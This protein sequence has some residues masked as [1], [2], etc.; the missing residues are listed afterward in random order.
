MPE[1]KILRI[2]LDETMLYQARQGTFGFASRVEKAFT[3][4]GFQV[5]FREN[6]FDERVK[7][8]ARNGYSMF[9][10]DDPFHEKA[11]T[12]RKAYY[13]PFWRIEATPKRWEFEVAQKTF[14]PDEIDTD[15]A[16]FWAGNWRKWLFK[17]GPANATQDGV[18]YV[19][20]QGRLLERRS[21]QSMSPMDMIEEVRRKA[22]ERHILLGLHPGETYSRDELD[23]VDRMSAKDGRIAVQTGGMEVALR[24]CDLVVTQNS[25][26]ALSGFFFRKPAVLFAQTDFHHQMPSALD[27][28]VDE[29]W[30]RAEEIIPRYAAYL[31][32]FI[33]LNAIKADVEGAAEAQILATCARHGWKI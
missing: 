5:E 29:A 30:R 26:A 25:A 14:D 32:W 4:R 2:Y 13:F 18:I 33:S 17:D 19:P 9:L 1:P 7:S 28:G 12:M 27:L 24:T 23:A 21:F 20:L 11:L 6:S 10:M 16:Q 8:G 22:G 31:Y 3:E 15:T